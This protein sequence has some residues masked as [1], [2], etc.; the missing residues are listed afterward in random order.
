MAPTKSAGNTKPP[1]TRRANTSRELH[2]TVGFATRTKKNALTATLKGTL[3]PMSTVRRDRIREGEA[4]GEQAMCPAAPPVS[5]RG[6]AARRR[7]F[8]RV[9]ILLAACACLGCTPVE[10]RV[11]TTPLGGEGAPTARANAEQCERF[12]SHLRALTFQEIRR[13][14][15]RVQEDPPT[16][17]WAMGQA[18]E[19]YRFARASC[20]ERGTVGEVRCAVQVPTL[21]ALSERCG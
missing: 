20:L 15:D 17:R 6:R 8:G 14:A 19:S 7:T 11:V 3:A 5:P 16:D 13:R 21:S 12:A 1:K 4:P 2:S 18:D 10:Y 9:R